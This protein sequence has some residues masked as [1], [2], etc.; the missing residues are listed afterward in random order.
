MS[1]KD[2]PDVEIP[3][4]RTLED[5]KNPII[6]TDKY[7]NNLPDHEKAGYEKIKRSETNE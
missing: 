1:Y 5:F 4:P 3:A 6:I 7:Y 2:I